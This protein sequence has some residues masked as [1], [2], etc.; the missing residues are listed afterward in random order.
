M[1]VFGSSPYIYYFDYTSNIKDLT[2]ETKI[3]IR[4]RCVNETTTHLKQPKLE[5]LFSP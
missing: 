2:E 4:Q 5:N 3:K 1:I